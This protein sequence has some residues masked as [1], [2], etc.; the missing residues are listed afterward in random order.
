ML[1]RHGVKERDVEG[2]KVL[3]AKNVYPMDIGK[4]TRRL[5]GGMQKYRSNR[6][7]VIQQRERWQRRR[8]MFKILCEAGH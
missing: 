8:K 1:V 4:R 5:G 3:T 7:L 2:K 6:K